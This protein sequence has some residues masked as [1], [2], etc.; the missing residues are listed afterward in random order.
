MNTILLRTVGAGIPF[1]FILLSG[2]GLT[3]SGKPYGVLVFTIHKLFS[4]GMVVLL[5]ITVRQA[6]QAMKLGTLEWLA[7]ILTGLFFLTTVVAG[8]LLSISDSM[9]TIVRKAHQITPYLTTV[10]TLITLYTLSKW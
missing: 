5:V 3:H 4:V 1:L 9:P 6:N 10:V 8:S 2:F 7:V